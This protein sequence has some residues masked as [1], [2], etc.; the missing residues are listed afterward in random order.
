[1]TVNG[2]HS[3]VFA[4]E[5]QSQLVG[6]SLDRPHVVAT[7]RAEFR[8]EIAKRRPAIAYVDIELLPQLEGD[9]D[10]MTV[11]GIVD[12]S[13]DS[14]VQAFNSFPRLSHVITTAM[15]NAPVAKTHLAALRER[16]EHGPEHPF[17][18]HDG[19]GRVALLTHSARRD[20]RF[21]RL[22][23]FFSKHIESERTITAIND[24]AEELVTNALYDAP[25]ESGYFATPVRRTEDVELPTEHACEI[26]YG[27]EA[28]RAFVRVRDPFGALTRSRLFGV[29]NRC[30]ASGVALDESRGGAGLGLWRVLSTVSTAAITVI[31]GRLTD[32]LV[33][34]DFKK[35]KGA[36]KQLLA[37]HLFLPEDCALDGER[38][39][40]AAEH[41][42]DLIDESFTA[43]I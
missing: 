28:G 15:L 25:A 37:T 12:G 4:R 11:V 1:V 5:R 14:I 22:R 40:F 23:D 13:I 34:L 2:K 32:V 26:S 35:A 39:R 16:L 9:I 27:V 30:N 17:L 24:V 10:I 36:G 8:A 31:P 29:L 7:S 43:V 19:I 6:A 20:S 3:L 18:G 42:D 33:W 38:S 41:D 21:E